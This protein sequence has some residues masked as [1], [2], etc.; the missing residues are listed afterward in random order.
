MNSS[1]NKE[2]AVYEMFR[3]KHTKE[4]F[5]MNRNSG[6]AAAGVCAAI[7]LTIVQ[8]QIKTE[9]AVSSITYACIAVPLCLLSAYVNEYFV[10]LGQKSYGFYETVRLPLRSINSVAGTLIIFSFSHAV[11]TITASG[12]QVLLVASGIALLLFFLFH[13]KLAQWLSKRR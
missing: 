7:V 11:R 9:D 4:Q 3:T 6:L 13:H 5:E 8:A 1:S 12:Y 10:F 2:D